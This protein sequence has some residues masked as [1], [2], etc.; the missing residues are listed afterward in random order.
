MCKILFSADL[1]ASSVLV[2]VARLMEARGRNALLKRRSL[3]AL[4]SHMIMKWPSAFGASGHIMLEMA[5]GTRLS[6]N[7]ALSHTGWA[8]LRGTLPGLRC[9]QPGLTD[10]PTPILALPA[11]VRS[12][13]ALS[14]GASVDT[15]CQLSLRSRSG[16]TLN[17]RGSRHV[18]LARLHSVESST[19]EC[20][21][22]ETPPNATCGVVTV[23]KT[24]I[25]RTEKLI[26]TSP[27]QLLG[28]ILAICWGRGSLPQVLSSGLVRWGTAG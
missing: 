2:R 16:T 25:Q 26:H 9:H 8:S 28:A 14:T 10:W 27:A 11:P 1:P 21:W 15:Y 3:P 19:S 6:L 12:F 18:A 20:N 5:G 13:C 23:A 4:A 7:L 17:L 22:D 24:E